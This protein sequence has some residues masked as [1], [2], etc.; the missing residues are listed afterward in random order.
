MSKTASMLVGTTVFFKIN[1]CY[2]H[3]PMRHCSCVR[4][5]SHRAGPCSPTSGDMPL[6]PPQERGSSARLSG[7]FHGPVPVTS[8]WDTW[9]GKGHHEAVGVRTVQR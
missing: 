2:K 7:P 9:G 4:S 3:P 8:S 1:S 5:V 6:P